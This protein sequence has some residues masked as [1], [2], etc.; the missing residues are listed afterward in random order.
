V[1]SA[2][3]A[4]AGAGVVAADLGTITRPD[5]TKQVTYNGHPLY[6]YSKDGDSGDAYGQGIMGFG[7]SW[8]V[9]APSGNKVDT[10]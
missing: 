9:I 10:S 3:A 7:A 4:T 5:G 1:T 2:G 6:F 8:Y